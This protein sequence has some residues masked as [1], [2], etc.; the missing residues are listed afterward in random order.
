MMSRAVDLAS[1][2]PL[3][4]TC[5]PG[6]SELTP[7]FLIGEFPRPQD[8]PWLRSE[9]GVSAVFSLQDDEDLWAKGLDLRLL[10]SAYAAHGVH[11]RRVAIPDYEPSRMIVSLDGLLR[12]LEQAFADGHRVYLHCNAGMN[13]AP[14]VAIAFFHVYRGYSLDA[15]RDLVKSRRPCA[16][17]MQLL[18]GYF[19]GARAED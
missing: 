13:R 3:A 15:A 18:H 7:N 6:F 8:V 1:T 17:Y 14:T 19:D 9:H 2:S 12:D 10:E 4:R 5:R 11:F 16:P